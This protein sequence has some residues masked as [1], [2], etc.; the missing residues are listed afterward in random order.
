[1]DFNSLFFPAPK[2]HYS[3]VTHFGEMIYLPK[4]TG[5]VAKLCFENNCFESH[6]VY[7]PCLFIKKTAPVVKEKKSLI[8]I[9]SWRS[10]TDPVH[11]GLFQQRNRSNITSNTVILNE[12]YE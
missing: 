4:V 6:Q 3:C 9:N 1:M 2:K 10:D 12:P 11:P 8:S 7:I 5:P